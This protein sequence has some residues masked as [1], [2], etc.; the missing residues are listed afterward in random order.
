VELEPVL[1]DP[2]DELE[3][4]ESEE[5]APLEA[6]EPSEPLVSLEPLEADPDVLPEPVVTAV[7]LVVRERAGSCPVTSTTAITP[8]TTMNNPTEYPMTRP[9]ILRTRARLSCLILSPSSEV[10]PAGLAVAVAGACGRRKNR[11]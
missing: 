7:L 4:A 11:V 10:I 3:P 2:P 5:L 8:H 9:R 6:P 1:F